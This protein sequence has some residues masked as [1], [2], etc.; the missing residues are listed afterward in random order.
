MMCSAS[1]DC[2]RLVIC[3]GM[4]RYHYHRQYT[5]AKTVRGIKKICS[6]Q[7]CGKPH[8][9][10]GYCN[11]HFMRYKK[12]GNALTVLKAPKRLISDLEA[13]L[14]VQHP[15]EYRSWCNMKTRCYY[16][17]DSRYDRYGGRGIKVCDRW[18]DSFENFYEDMGSKPTPKHT[19]DRKN[20]DGDYEPSNCKWSTV[21]AQNANRSISN[22]IMGVGYYKKNDTWWAQLKVN[23][24]IVLNKTF[25]T[26]PEAIAARRK[27]ELD[28]MVDTSH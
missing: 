2:S 8:K 4:C 11:A 12:H 19:L 1:E 15:Y 25:Q 22:K 24:A 28:F 14:R 27:A 3:K 9:G 13:T 5:G 21:R 6:I 18:R 16:Q 23:G 10:R 20:N 7:D 26:E 17:K